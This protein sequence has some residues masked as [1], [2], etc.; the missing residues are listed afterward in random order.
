MAILPILLY[1]DE[2]LKQ[3]SAPIEAIDDAVKSLIDDLLETLYESPGC[4]GIAAPQVGALQRMVIVDASR[5]AKAGSNH[6]RMILIN[7]EVLFSEGEVMAREGCLS[8]PH[9]TANVKRAQHIKVRAQNEHG[10]WWEF[11]SSD[12]E[13][14]VVLHE[15][16]HLDGLLFLDRVAS[17]KTDVFRRKRYTP[18]EQQ[19]ARS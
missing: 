18:P 11:E 6:G 19:P 13:A 12:F 10:E 14:R 17:L 9:L 8:L 3:I 1:P 16:D 7:P 5:N 15:M 2:R 4:V